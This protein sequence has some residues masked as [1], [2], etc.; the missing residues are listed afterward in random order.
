MASAP[1]EEQ[2]PLTIAAEWA[3]AHN[4]DT[5]R[6]LVLARGPL[7]QPHTAA[8]FRADALSPTMLEAC[9]RTNLGNVLRSVEFFRKGLVALLCPGLVLLREGRAEAYVGTRQGL[10]IDL[11]HATKWALRVGY[12]RIVTRPWAGP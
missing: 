5:C 9:I 11:L 10:S 12:R 8:G 4:L 2:Q 1:W 7:Q 6:P 3:L